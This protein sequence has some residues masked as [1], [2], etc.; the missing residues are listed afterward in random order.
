MRPQSMPKS[1]PGWS[2]LPGGNFA[3]NFTRSLVGN[4]IEVGVKGRVRVS[5]INCGE[6]NAE[7]VGISKDGG[8]NSASLMEID[9]RRK[10]YIRGNNVIFNHSFTQ[11]ILKGCL[12]RHPAGRLP[13]TQQ[14]NGNGENITN[15]ISYIKH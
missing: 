3:A 2:Y 7:G 14:N 6:Q 10:F 1:A 13:W 11:F 4:E 15:E 5:V 8:D 12:S 9:L